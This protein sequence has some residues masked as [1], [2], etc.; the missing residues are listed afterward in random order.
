MREFL[1]AASFYLRLGPHLCPQIIKLG[2]D[3]TKPNLL[4]IFL[5]ILETVYRKNEEHAELYL[6]R[7]D[8]LFRAT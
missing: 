8:K 1:P 4:S 5:N 7:R 6:V 2:I 3:K